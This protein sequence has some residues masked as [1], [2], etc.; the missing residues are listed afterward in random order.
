MVTV[1][2]LAHVCAL[3]GLINVFVLSAAR[4]LRSQ[5][6]LQE[7]VV[8]SLL[9]PLLIGDVLHISVTLWALG[10][11]RW[12]VTEWSAVLWATIILGLSLLIPRITW[13]LGIGRYVHSRDAR[14]RKA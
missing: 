4:Q 9:M 6:A 5:P 12:H 1:V 13:H 3:M 14:A 11:V 7:K 2:Q 10:D 8:T